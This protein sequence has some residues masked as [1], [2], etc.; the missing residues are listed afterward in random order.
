MKY[1]VKLKNKE[2][3]F[4]IEKDMFNREEHWIIMFESGRKLYIPR[5]NIEWI[6]EKH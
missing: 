3:V 4:T 5:E 6:E 1:V 2:E